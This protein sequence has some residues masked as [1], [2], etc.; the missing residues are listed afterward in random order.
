[1]PGLVQRL[2]LDFHHRH[3]RHPCLRLGLDLVE[4]KIDQSWCLYQEFFQLCYMDL[5]Y[6]GALRM[7]STALNHYSPV[8]HSLQ[9]E[10]Q[11]QKILEYRKSFQIV[12]GLDCMR[13]LMLV[14]VM[15]T[16]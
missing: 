3:L 13:G 16:P 5:M 12:S 6:Q 15:E 9:N 8:G 11:L 1:M 10:D 4:V 7:H 2:V 14:A